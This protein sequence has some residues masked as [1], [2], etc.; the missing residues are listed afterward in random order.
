M[1]ASLSSW[2]LSREQIFQDKDNGRSKEELSPAW[3]ENKETTYFSFLRSRRS[4]RLHKDFCAKRLLR[5]QRTQ[6]TPDHNMFF[7][8]TLALESIL[9]KSCACTRRPWGRPNN[10][11]RARQAR[12]LAKELPHISDVNYTEGA[13]PSLSPP[14]CVHLHILFPS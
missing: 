9:A 5:G 6:G 2:N 13:T 1:G 11:L 4:P 7:P 14:T 3:R 10:G 8:E 12:W